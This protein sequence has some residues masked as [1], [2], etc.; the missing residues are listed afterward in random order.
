MLSFIPSYKLEKILKELH[1]DIVLLAQELACLSE[2]EKAWLHKAVLISTI[3]AS[4]RIENA[5]L[6]DAEIEWVDTTLTLDGKTTS[7][8]E[9]RMDILD[10]LSKDRERS[11]EEVV[12]L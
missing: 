4:T 5:A 11:I 7:Y 8:E 3:G 2:T 12:A 9:K 1:G 10:K 6:T